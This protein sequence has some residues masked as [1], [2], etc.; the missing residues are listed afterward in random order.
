MSEW[1]CYVKPLRGARGGAAV[2]IPSWVPNSGRILRDALDVFI[3][4]EDPEARDVPGLRMPVDGV[5]TPQSGELGVRKSVGER[6][7]VREIQYWRA[8]T[9]RIGGEDTA[10]LETSA[11]RSPGAGA[12]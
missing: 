12:R 9:T 3:A 5:A 10:H 2:S 4:R 8:S 6:I 7:G 11:G 1:G